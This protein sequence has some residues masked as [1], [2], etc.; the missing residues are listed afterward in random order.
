MRCQQ[1]TRP[2]ICFGQVR[3]CDLPRKIVSYFEVEQYALARLG[4]LVGGP[5]TGTP[6]VASLL[7]LEEGSNQAITMRKGDPKAFAGDLS[8]L[9]LLNLHNSSNML[10]E[11]CCSAGRLIESNEML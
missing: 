11:A 9:A 7:Q 8:V 3:R 5:Y 4:R 1:H 2:L 10:H 6:D